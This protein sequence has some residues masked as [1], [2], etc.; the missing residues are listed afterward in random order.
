[1]VW[2]NRNLTQADAQEKINDY[3]TQRDAGN[4]TVPEHV[5]SAIAE[6]RDTVQDGLAEDRYQRAYGDSAP[7]VDWW[8]DDDGKSSYLFDHPDEPK[9]GY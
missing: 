9:K 6:A 3:R 1:M 7:P 5:T 4:T 2:N 8:E